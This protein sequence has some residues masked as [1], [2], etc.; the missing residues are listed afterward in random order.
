MEVH[1]NAEKIKLRCL[2]IFFFLI[3][4]S[5]N[6]RKMK[7]DPFITAFSNGRNERLYALKFSLSGRK[8][9]NIISPFIPKVKAHINGL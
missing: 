1:K 7:V 5:A 6:K 3:A 2:F 8:K 4:S 9:A